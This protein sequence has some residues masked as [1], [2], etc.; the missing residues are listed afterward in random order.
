MSSAGLPAEKCL[1]NRKQQPENKRF[2]CQHSGTEWGRPCSIFANI[3]LLLVPALRSESFHQ[4]PYLEHVQSTPA[5]PSTSTSRLHLFHFLCPAQWD[6]CFSSS[7]IW[8]L[9]NCW[10]VLKNKTL[11]SSAST[12]KHC[13]LRGQHLAPRKTNFSSSWR[14]QHLIG[15]QEEHI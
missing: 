15:G 8:K 14:L 13:P 7:H 11:Y 10:N 12:Q 6:W 1:H 2:I 9:E 4:M 5:I 3:Y